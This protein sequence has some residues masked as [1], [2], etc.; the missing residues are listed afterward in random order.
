MNEFY[1]QSATPKQGC[2]RKCCVEKA[3]RQR[4]PNRGKFLVKPVILPGKME[5]PGNHDMYVLP[6]WTETYSF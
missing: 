1:I 3:S 4:T 6:I 2:R 5:V